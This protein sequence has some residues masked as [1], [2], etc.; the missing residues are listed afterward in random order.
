MQKRCPNTRTPRPCTAVRTPSSRDGVRT[1]V[2]ALARSAPYARHGLLMAG[3]ALGRGSARHLRA[4]DH[5]RGRACAR[6]LSVSRRALQEGV[7]RLARP[8]GLSDGLAFPYSGFGSRRPA[9]RSCGTAPSRRCPAP[10]SPTS[11]W[12]TPAMRCTRVREHPFLSRLVLW[13]QHSGGVGSVA[14]CAQHLSRRVDGKL[15]CG[16]ALVHSP[17]ARH[18]LGDICSQR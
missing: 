4:A 3:L 15:V 7:V 12:V 6:V 18:T 2:S 5:A 1:A 8:P 9:G 16:D 13:F 17:E 10:P 11:E 14:G